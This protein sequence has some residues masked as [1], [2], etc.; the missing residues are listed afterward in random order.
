[1]LRDR[2]RRV[3]DAPVLQAGCAC[4]RTTPGVG[5]NPASSTP[6]SVLRSGRGGRADSRCSRRVPKGSQGPK[7]RNAPRSAPAG[8]LMWQHVGSANSEEGIGRAAR[9][10]PRPARITAASAG[11]RLSDDARPR[12]G[13]ACCSTATRRG[14]GCAPAS[15]SAKS[16]RKRRAAADHHAQSPEQ[17]A[18]LSISP[19]R[20]EPSAPPPPRRSSPS[21]WRAPGA[22][23]S[24]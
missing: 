20:P 6:L 24:C 2:R 13:R 7:K 10:R 12:A 5:T 23:W 1:M 3:S 9:L 15:S 21:C 19:S 18:S 11:H 4:A 22:S 8:K 14:R 17:P 16:P